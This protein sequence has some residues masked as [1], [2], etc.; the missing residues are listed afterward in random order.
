MN[1]KNVENLLTSCG[2]LLWQDEVWKPHPDAMV[3]WSSDYDAE[4]HLLIHQ[5][6]KT[7]SELCVDE[8]SRKSIRKYFKL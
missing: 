7:C 6:A 2:F 3:D 8:A 5:V 4:I 1:R